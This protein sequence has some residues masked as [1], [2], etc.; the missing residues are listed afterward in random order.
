MSALH[1]GRS[2]AS[3]HHD[4][5]LVICDGST[6]VSKATGSAPVR[7]AAPPRSAAAASP[8]AAVCACDQRHAHRH[9]A[10]LEPADRLLDLQPQFLALARV[11]ERAGGE[12]RNAVADRRDR[13]L[14]QVR[15][16]GPPAAPRVQQRFQVAPDRIAQRDQRIA[17][18][19][20][21]DHAPDPAHVDQ[22]VEQRRL[23]RGSRLSDPARRA[24][25]CAEPQR[26]QGPSTS[27]PSSPTRNSRWP[28]PRTDPPS[29]SRQ[30]VSRPSRSASVDRLVGRHRWRAYRHRRPARRP[31]TSTPAARSGRAAASAG[32]TRTDYPFGRDPEIFAGGRQHL[33]A[34]GQQIVG[35]AEVVERRVAVQARRAR[36]HLPR[37]AAACSPPR[38]ASP[39]RSATS[40][41]ELQAAALR[42]ARRG[43]PAPGRRGTAAAA[44]CRRAA[45]GGT[46][47]PPAR[48]SDRSPWRR[49]GTT[50]ARSR[51]P[52]N[53]SS[54]ASRT[55]ASRSVGRLAQRRLRGGDGVGQLAGAQQ[56]G[57]V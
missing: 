20:P 22:P 6:N 52:A 37:P 11:V 15:R 16:P 45:T 30:S 35:I 21:V 2:G 24:R 55:R 18:P 47:P 36:P 8:P 29:A 32:G 19:R 48:W 50:S 56:R 12:I 54:S 34:A 40:G 44:P 49:R 41:G 57:G 25:S 43:T 23:E 13:K 17:R 9:E 31:P 26:C 42:S 53:T 14:L 7:R 3:R 1:G 10:R 39:A 51:L 28:T 27:T 33:E 4:R 38:P 5:H 46:P